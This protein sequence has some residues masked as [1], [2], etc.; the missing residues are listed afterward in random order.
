M[1]IY[2]CLR[3]TCKEW[4]KST[5]GQ[6][7]PLFSYPFNQWKSHVTAASPSVHSN[8][9][10]L[11]R[12]APSACPACTLQPRC[13]PHIVLTVSSLL[14]TLPQVLIVLRINSKSLRMA[15]NTLPD[16]AL[17][18]LDPH[19]PPL[20]AHQGP[21]VIWLPLFLQDSSHIS[22][23]TVGMICSYGCLLHYTVKSDG[24]DWL[25]LCL[26]PS[27]CGTEIK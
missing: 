5:Q 2:G 15:C 20:P 21:L 16:L 9:F 23:Y 12:L 14:Q 17:Q 26:D 3:A 10:P 7:C 18:R 19:G 13:A 11:G 24:S 1:A 22:Y 25:R 6:C 4:L 8:T 27:L